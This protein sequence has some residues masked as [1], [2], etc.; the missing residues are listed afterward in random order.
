MSNQ[1]KSVFSKTKIDDATLIR[2][3]K[4]ASLRKEKRSEFLTKR[5]MGVVVDQHA[6][7]SGSIDDFQLKY[8]IVQTILVSFLASSTYAFIEY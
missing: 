8:Q 3:K 1:R 6:S 5:R 2:S 4:S 7:N